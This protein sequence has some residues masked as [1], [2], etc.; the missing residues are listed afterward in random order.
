MQDSVTLTI[1]YLAYTTSEAERS[2]PTVSKRRRGAY[3][4][5]VSQRLER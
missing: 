2:T 4:R 3:L 1:V 5:T